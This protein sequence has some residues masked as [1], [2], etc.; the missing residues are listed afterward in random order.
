MATTWLSAIA[1]LIMA[2]AI[3]TASPYQ[4]DDELMEMKRYLEQERGHKSIPG[5][6]PRSYIPQ[7]DDDEEELIATMVQTER[8]PEEYVSLTV[9]QVGGV[10]VD[11][12]KNCHVFHRG[13]TVWTN[14]TFD[15]KN[16]F[17]H[18]ADGPIRQAA[19]MVLDNLDGKV[20]HRWGYKTFYM[21]H[22][23]TLDQ[24]GNTWLTDVA[25]HQVFKYAPGT[26]E[27]ALVLGKAFE[28]ATSNNDP[29]R[30]CK[31]TDV[32]VAS[33]GDFYVSD[34]YCNSRVLKYS[35]DGKLIGQIGKPDDFNVP[36]S[37]ALAENLDVLCIADRDNER[38]VCVNAGI[39]DPTKFGEHYITY[40]RGPDGH[41][42][43]NEMDS[44]G[45]VFGIAYSPKEGFLYVVSE[46]S[47]RQ[48]PHAY[49]IDLR[50]RDM[51]H[52][53]IVAEWTPSQVDFFEPHDIDVSEDGEVAYVGLIDDDER[54]TH[55]VWKFNTAYDEE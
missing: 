13:R 27:P 32:A 4:S 35:K 26:R 50:E 1:I 11:K 24:E 31:P 25:L 52:T 38:I 33:N 55:K 39:S 21:P 45:R 19:V 15:M 5:Q 6:D 18:K 7:E 54:N 9:G 22:G 30:F 44:I 46:S 36:H 14:D 8:W 40:S 16:N 37:L 3:I 34:G 41:D 43:R 47:Y 20:L 23:I 2:P 48:Q 12:K 51:F 49:T 28:P 10:A 29:E 42:P 53:D 17:M